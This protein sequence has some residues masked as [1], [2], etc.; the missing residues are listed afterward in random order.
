MFQS[1]ETMLRWGWLPLGITSTDSIPEVISPGRMSVVFSSPKFLVAFLAGTLMALAFQLLLTNFSVAVGISSWDNDPDDDDSSGSL[2]HSI[3][4]VEAKVGL[5]AL[6]SASIA[7]FIACF[8][9]VKLSL[10]QSAL[11]GAII[12]VVIWSTFFSLVVWFGSSAI[13][14]LIGSLASTLT[15]GLQTLTGTATAGIGASMA[16]RQMVSTAEEITAAVRR[17]LTSG[18]DPDNIRNTLQSSLSSLQIPNLDLKDIRSQ[19]DKILSDVDFGSIANSDVLRNVNR[20]TFVD[21]ISNRTKLSAGDINKIADQLQAAWTQASSRKNPTEQVINLLKS[22]TPEELNSEKLGERLQELVTV[23]GNG[24]GNGNGSNG[25]LKQAAQ[26]GVGAAIPAVLDRVDF[27]T[28]DIGKLTNQLQ[29]LKDKVQDIDVEKI[30]HELQS[31][32]DKTTEQ[33]TEKLPSSNRNNIKADVEDYISNSFPWHFNRLTIKDEFQELIYD[34]QADPA[35]TSRELEEINENYITSLLSRRDDLSEAR[36]KEISQ[37][38]E[39]I[40]QEVLATVQQSSAKD[41]W[42]D[43]RS[44]LENYLRS[45]GKDELKPENVERNFTE[46]LQD[47]QVA[48]AE[49]SVD[50]QRLVDRH[51]LSQFDRDTFVQLLQQRQDID[52]EQINNIIGQLESTRDSILN[53]ARELQEQAQAKTAELRQRVEDYLRNTNK[54][55]LN[56]DGIKRDFRTLLEDPQAGFAALKERLS[57]FDRDT[58]VQLLSQRQDLSEDQVNQIIHQLEGVR[59]NILQAPQAVAD[60]AKEQYEQTST[61]I[62]EYLRN[63]NLEELNPEGIRKDLETLLSDPQQGAVALRDR[64]SQ[65]DRDTLVQLLSQREGLSEEQVNRTID[66][67]QEAINSIVKAPRRLVNRTSQRVIDFEKTL[68]NYLRHTNKEELNPDSIKRDLQLLLQDPRLGIGNLAE[69]LSRFDRST[70]V[71]LLSQREDISEEE[72]NRIVD[73]ILSI[74]ESLGKQYQQIQQRVQSVINGVFDRF[75][76]YLNSLDRPE[77]NYES[78]QQDF[79]KVFDDPQAGFEALRDRLSHFDRDTLVALISSRSD[80]SEEDANGII[81][82]IEAARDRVLHRAERIQEE[83]QKRIKAIQHQA[84]KQVEETKKT[85]ASAAWW[86]FGTAF[87]SLVASAIAGVIAATG[88]LNFIG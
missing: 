36:I 71:A 37:Q 22:A 53:S 65:F 74:S 33:I 49:L 59:D 55:E 17:E 39:S 43:V 8:L 68:E 2:G 83:A 80:I 4:K 13:G 87:T 48:F 58:F 6:V 38:L 70:I 16:Q 29:K 14:S 3:R 61:K 76:N 78:I 26:Y 30:T 51:R 27:S 15:S 63:T 64:L 21:L 5:W 25:V 85:V 1:F 56:P 66:Q 47:P 69:R 84:K 72:A 20:Q 45:T 86:L 62:A 28:V 32:T 7:L 23:G 9:A 77:L 81:D 73:Q 54:D 42:Q 24:S 11:F 34:P 79:A 18:F 19:F 44:Q 50:A 41:K 31:F 82:R 88:G 52:D 46:I 60:K 10:I 12:G 75:R 57:Q 40:R 67:V 35:T